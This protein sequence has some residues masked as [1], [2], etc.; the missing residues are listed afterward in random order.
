MR[1]AIPATIRVIGAERLPVDDATM[2]RLNRAIDRYA[3]RVA[4][5]VQNEHALTIHPRAYERTGSAQRYEVGV[6]L[7]Y[8]GERIATS[9][10][11]WALVATVRSALR[12]L[13]EAY[14]SKFKDNGPIGSPG[15]RA[16]YTATE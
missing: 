13:L 5:A 11:G 7:D 3:E 14:E 8:P 12:K 15:T 9:D 4:R 1:T 16:L 6:R 10:E 2:H